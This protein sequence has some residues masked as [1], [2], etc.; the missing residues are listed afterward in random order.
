MCH[1][2]KLLK[3]VLEIVPGDGIFWVGSFLSDNLPW[4]S[5]LQIRKQRPNR[6]FK[7]LGEDPPTQVFKLQVRTLCTLPLT[8]FLY[9]MFHCQQ[10]IIRPIL[11]LGEAKNIVLQIILQHFF[12]FSTLLSTLFLVPYCFPC[13]VSQM[14]PSYQFALQ[15]FFYPPFNSSH[16]HGFLTQVKV[17][18][19]FTGYLGIK[20]QKDL[21]NG[22]LNLGFIS[23]YQLQE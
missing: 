15:M 17:L 23:F 12:P 2:S 18:I 21:T 22:R 5:I 1:Y 11:A 19:G 14:E 8:K 7:W 10:W 4:H 9:K 20:Q 13:L 16:Q 6:S 3:T